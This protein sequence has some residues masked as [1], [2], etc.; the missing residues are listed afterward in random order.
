[1]YIYVYTL[2]TRVWVVVDKT[3]QCNELGMKKKG[4]AKNFLKIL[5]IC[6][7]WLHRFL[8]IVGFLWVLSKGR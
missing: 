2:I 8:Q 3:D 5:E 7:G 1:M 6:M 4:L